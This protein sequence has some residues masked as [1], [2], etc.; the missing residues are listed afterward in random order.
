MKTCF[1]CK[2]TYPLESFHKHS[3]MRDGRL[4]KCKH[5]VKKDVQ[6]WRKK[7]PDARKKE[8]ERRR[9]REG[10][11][12]REEYFEKRREA[13]IGRKVSATKYAHKRYRQTQTSFNPELDEFVFEE[14]IALCE[15]REKT[16]GTKWHVDH[17]VP[18]NHRKAC[19]LHVADNFQV[20]PA[21]WN[22]RKNNKSMDTFI[23]DNAIAGY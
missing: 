7:N 12:A 9:T 22:F 18:L 2:E 14:A 6:E 8:H 13:A 17:I 23:F 1:K 21:Y 5:C 11:M 15:L 3:K 19:G 10:L 4:N 16:T 20:V